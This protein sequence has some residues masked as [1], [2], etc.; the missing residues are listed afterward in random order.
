MH[1]TP[2]PAC[3]LVIIVVAHHVNDFIR[4]PIGGRTQHTLC[5]TCISPLPPLFPP[6]LPVLCLITFFENATAVSGLARLYVQEKALVE[7]RRA[8]AAACRHLGVREGYYPT[9]L[10]VENDEPH[11]ALGRTA[12]KRLRA[13]LLGRVKIGLFVF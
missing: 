3:A 10:P 8:A 6:R 13:S 7:G 4:K 12:F 11:I 2:S 1:Y 5:L 9:I